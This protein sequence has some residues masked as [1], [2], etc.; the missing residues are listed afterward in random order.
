MTVTLTS[1]YRDTLAPETVAVIDRLV[2]DQYALDHMLVFIDEHN[3]E[4]FREYY[5]EYVEL[6]ENHGYEAVD[7]F[8]N[9]VGDL[10]ELDRFENAY[11]GEYSSSAR[12]AEDFLDDEVDRL[13]YMIVVDWEATAEYL[14]DHDVDRYGDHYFRCYY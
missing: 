8:I 3:E 6:G 12:M 14:L 5:E 7:Y 11:I 13:H 1:S 4:E 10:D 9:N 2:E